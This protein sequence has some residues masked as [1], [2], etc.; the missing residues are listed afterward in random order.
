MEEQQK[1]CLNLWE[2]EAGSSSGHG[3]GFSGGGGFS[4]R[5]W[6]PEEAEEPFKE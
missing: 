2:A 3:G 1:L 6:T 5:R 4:R